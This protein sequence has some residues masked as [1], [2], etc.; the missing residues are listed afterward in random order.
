MRNSEEKIYFLEL[1]LREEE[2]KLLESLMVEGDVSIEDVVERIVENLAA[3]AMLIS[4]E[5]TERILRIAD[6]EDKIVELVEAAA[7]RSGSAYIATW[8]V[9]P[10]WLPAIQDIA[11][12]RGTTVDQVIQEAMDFMMDQGHL[13][14]TTQEPK[15]IRFPES[16]WRQLTQALGK[17]DIYYTD[18]LELVSRK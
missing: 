3:G 2:R 16:A 1:S 13:F 6:S 12:T 5:A 8:K 15:R 14:F 11:R 17:K 9:D 4:P 10:A 7:S 18:I